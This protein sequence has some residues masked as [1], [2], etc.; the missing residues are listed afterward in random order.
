MFHSIHIPSPEAS[1]KA[2]AAT[3][4]LLYTQEIQVEMGGAILDVEYTYKPY[5]E[6]RGDNPP[7]PAE[8]SIDSIRCLGSS[9]LYAL[10][11]SYRFDFNRLHETL[12]ENHASLSHL[13]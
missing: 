11:E 12:I 13:A 3:P 5:V 8:V 9:D 6:A 7:E 2:H 10:L 1:K 4:Q